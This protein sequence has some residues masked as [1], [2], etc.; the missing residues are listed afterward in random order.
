MEH[1][2][3]FLEI[4][5]EEVNGADLLPI[6]RCSITPR[7]QESLSSLNLDPQISDASKP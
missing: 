7:S 4:V 2:L 3:E 1:V 6:K 5:I